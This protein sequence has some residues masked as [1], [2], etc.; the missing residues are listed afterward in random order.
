MNPPPPAGSFVEFAPAVAEGESPTTALPFSFPR[1]SARPRA[2]TDRRRR[3]GVGFGEDTGS[4]AALRRDAVFRRALAIADVLAAAAAV[5]ICAIVFGDVEPWAFAVLPLVIVASKAIGLYDRDELVIAK[6]TLD[7][8]P[9]LFQLVT[10]YALV[11]V[12]I[13]SAIST[14]PIDPVEL[15]T[16]WSLLFV[17]THCARS[18]A[19]LVA[20]RMSPPERCALLGDLDSA[21]RLRAK[22]VRHR[23]LDADLA[24][25]IPF[26][27]FASA[28]DARTRLGEYL[29]VSDFDR[30]IVAQSDANAAEVLEAVRYFK[31]LG[32]KVSVLPR[33]LDVVGSAVE[34][35]DIHGSTLLGVRRFGLSRSSRLLKRTLDV[36][37]AALTLIVCAPL[38]A[39]AALAIKLTSRGPVLFRQTRVGRDGRRFSIVK[40]RTMVQ[41]ADKLKDDL[42]H[43]NEAEGL[44]KISEDPRISR[45]GR[46]LRRSSL[47]ELPQ[48]LNVL[49]GE[50]SLVGPRPLVVDEDERVEGWHRRRLHLTPGMTGAWQIAGSARVPLDE[51]VAMDYLYIVNWSLWSDIKILLRTTPHVLGRR[52]Q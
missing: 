3:A 50:M 22:L 5:L 6:T 38:I 48:L 33:L 47:D 2:R 21:D 16:M 43:L 39:A 49:R 23:E 20:R 41:G 19:R 29:R 34:F 28:S 1:R 37:G 25:W 4:R 9:A 7:E 40:F 32:I 12:L 17:G 13:Q 11:I 26:E 52:G 42:L 35:D 15:V 24:A 8:T 45:A 30:V 14:K 18:G 10:I 36:I 51:M 27:Q 31:A 46:F 44:F